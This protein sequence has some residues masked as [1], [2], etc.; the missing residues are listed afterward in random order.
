MKTQ[1]SIMP[2]WPV[3]AQTAG[4]LSCIDLDLASSSGIQS[5]FSRCITIMAH[6]YLPPLA[7]L[8]R[9][10]PLWVST[11]PYLGNCI[12]K[13]S[14][15]FVL[16]FV[17]SCA[18]VSDFFDPMHCSQPDPSVHGILQARILEKVAIH[19]SR[20]SSQPRDRTS[21]SCIASWLFTIW[22]TR[23]AYTYTRKI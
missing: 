19:F 2:G 7:F 14:V 5:C 16:Q 6:Q 13:L 4:S 12:F 11:T 9:I 20:G 3:W 8:I 10:A 22:A 15:D 18:A 17:L 23:E 1:M 21:V